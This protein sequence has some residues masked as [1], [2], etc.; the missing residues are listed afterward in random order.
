MISGR[1]ASSGS[2]DPEDPPDQITIEDLRVDC[3]VGIY[4][5]ERETP[6][7]VEITAELDV[8][9]AAAA[10]SGKLADTVDYAAAANAIVRLVQEGKFHLL[11]TMAAA[12]AELLLGTTT[13]DRV[14]LR[15]RKPRA[16]PGARCAR[17]DIVRRKQAGQN[18]T[19]RLTKP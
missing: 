11:E 3:I 4:P 5:E 16:I 19:A 14:R 1:L 12:I 7:P 17:L 9:T 6:Q 18:A 8:D 10:A 15:I 2:T 13:A